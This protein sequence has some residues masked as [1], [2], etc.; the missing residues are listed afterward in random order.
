VRKLAGFGGNVAESIQQWVSETSRKPKFDVEFRISS[1]IL[2]INGSR[3]QISKQ[4]R[5][6]ERMSREILPERST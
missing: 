1:E 6:P 4:I 3:I 5:S 2:P